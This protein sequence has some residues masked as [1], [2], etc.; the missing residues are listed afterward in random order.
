MRLTGFS[1]EAGGANDIWICKCR[2]KYVKSHINETLRVLSLAVKSK[3]GFQKL[4]R[5]KSSRGCFRGD[6]TFSS[7]YLTLLDD[8]VGEAK[9]VFLAKMA[10]SSVVCRLGYQLRA[11]AGF[12]R[13]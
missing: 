2:I 9:L 6:I 12:G 7:W 5:T 3:R 4:L 1:D 13:Q 8:W 11:S 10:V